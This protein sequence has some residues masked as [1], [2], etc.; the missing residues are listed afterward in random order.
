MLVSSVHY[1]CLILI[2]IKFNFMLI[3]LSPCCIYI[4]IYSRNGFYCALSAA[5]A[6]SFQQLL[7]CYS[8][9]DSSPP[10]W[11][12]HSPLLCSDTAVTRGESKSSHYNR[13]WINHHQE[14]SISLPYIDRLVECLNSGKADSRDIILSLALTSML[15][16][17]LATSRLKSS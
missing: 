5:K 10:P 6:A 1:Y 9:Q 8:L 15:F 14:E 4:Y 13:Y 12:S 17:Q 11:Q 3:I 7:Q 16:L 2:S